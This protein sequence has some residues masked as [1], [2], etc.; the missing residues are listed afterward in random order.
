MRRDK[1]TCTVRALRPHRSHH[2]DRGLCAISARS[3]QA[4][5]AGRSA[6]RASRNAIAISP[7]S[8]LA[9]RRLRRI[10]TARG[11][12]VGQLFFEPRNVAR[13][14]ASSRA[15]AA[16]RRR[17]GAARATSR[18]ASRT[19]SFLPTISLRRTGSAARGRAPAARARAPCRCRRPSAVC[20]T[21][22]ARLS[23]RSRLLAALRERPTA[24]AAWSCVSWNSSIRRCSPCASSSGF[25]SSRWMFSIS[26][27]TAA[28]S[29]G[30]SCTSTG[31]S[32]R[33]ASLAARKRRSPAMIS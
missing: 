26:D 25:R 28:D 12:R 27:I 21:G 29:S 19:D 17:A 10:S 18:S 24:C 11:Q 15:A 14:L 23:R 3:V 30:T 31:T 8:P 22:V 9:P 7:W 13:L 33:P 5:R 32:S 6:R 16:L 2:V 1:R 4:C 20:C